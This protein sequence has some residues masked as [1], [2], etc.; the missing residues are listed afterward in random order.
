[1]NYRWL[2]PCR[3][4]RFDLCNN[5]PC[6]QDVGARRLEK[7]D[8]KIARLAFSKYRDCHL[9]TGSVPIQYRLKLSE[10]AHVVP[11]D[12]LNDVAENQATVRRPR[13]S[14]KASPVSVCPWLDLEN[15]HSAEPQSGSHEGVEVR[16]HS[17]AKSRGCVLTILN[18]LRDHT[19]HSV[20]RN[21]EADTSRRTG[22]AVDR[23]VDSDEPTTAIKQRPTGVSWVDGRVG[24]NGILNRATADRSNLTTQRRHDASGQRRTESEW[25]AN[26][27]DALADLNV[28]AAADGDRS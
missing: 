10:A 16:T 24:L 27:E 25:V 14:L 8:T 22:R 5:A 18:N 13:R 20:H 3:R 6:G 17:N 7:L 2:G 28:V 11:I 1:M 4:T 23:G 15:H 26:R 12:G 21:R 19:T 9:V